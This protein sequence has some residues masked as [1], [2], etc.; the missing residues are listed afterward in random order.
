MMKTWLSRLA[1]TASLV[2]AASAAAAA[3]SIV[4]DASSGQVIHAEQATDPWYP[5]SL[6][7]LMTAYVALRMVADGRASLDTP[8]RVTATAARQRPS[9]IGVRP[10][11]EITLDNALKIM[12]VKSANDV[13][14]VI[15]E[16][17]GGSIDGFA[18]MMNSEARRLGMRESRFLNPNGLHNPGMSTSARDMAILARAVLNEFPQ[19]RDLWGIGALQ[20]GNRVLRNTNG[21]IG[22]YSGADG[23]KTGFI[24]ASGFNVVA[25]AS[26]YGRTLITVVLGSP[27]SSERTA[28]A[29]E[30]FDKGFNGGGWG[31]GGSGSVSALPVSA[32]SGPTDQRYNI[33]GPG[34]KSR[35]PLFEEE[36]FALPS[37]SLSMMDNHNPVLDM[38]PGSRVSR[39]PGAGLSGYRAMARSP[40]PEFV[41]LRVFL[42]RAPGSDTAPN[43][44]AVAAKPAPAKPAA[45]A[46]AATPAAKP[47]A[48]PAALSGKPIKLQGAADE[49]DDVPAAKPRG[50]GKKLAVK[51]GK[52]KGKQVA[53]GAKPKKKVE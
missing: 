48:V 44:T 52:A 9:K 23:M 34:R 36:E 38:L 16:G 2:S 4:I 49:D 5:A 53:A 47:P 31:G 17:L 20:L 26:R 39:S 13:A 1:V 7:K 8:L 28:L 24:C 21:L 45:A 37:A 51:P 43:P 10:G 27:S 50:K 6:T 33:C 35:G 42:G 12:M 46:F 40:R 3:P 11:T 14:V 18:G 41:P 29:S 32:Y 25:T 15:A 30:L 19:H 22:R